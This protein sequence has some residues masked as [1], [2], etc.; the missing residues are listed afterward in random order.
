MMTF[1][2]PRDLIA[3]SHTCRLLNWK[4]FN[5]TQPGWYI[6][7]D[8]VQR[9]VALSIRSIISSSSR[10]DDSASFES[11]IG[12]SSGTTNR[13]RAVTKDPTAPRKNA[14]V[15]VDDDGNVID[16][17]G[18]IVRRLP[19]SEVEVIANAESSFTASSTAR[20]DRQQTEISD[21]KSSSERLPTRS[22]KRR[23]DFGSRPSSGDSG[24]DSDSDGSHQSQETDNEFDSS[25]SDA[26]SVAEQDSAVDPNSATVI[27]CLSHPYL[28]EDALDLQSLL[29]DEES[30][31]S[32]IRDLQ[33]FSKLSKTAQLAGEPLYNDLL[34][35]LKNN[36]LTRTTP[37]HFVFLERIGVWGDVGRA[38]IRFD[39]GLL[40]KVR[41]NGRTT[42]RVRTGACYGIF[43]DRAFQ[44][45]CL[46]AVLANRNKELRWLFNKVARGENL[47][48]EDLARL[49]SARRLMGVSGVYLI[50]IEVG[51]YSY[52][53]R[54]GC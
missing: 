25:G 53:P 40:R 16:L 32:D 42:Q 18:R 54:M 10:T 43:A 7:Q 4:V 28:S 27:P 26:Q 31:R 2:T 41:L 38:D 19:D 14:M 6:K 37:A 17:P 47:T 51:K 35:T 8:P 9:H 20:P 34:I 46:L 50:W 45:E 33:E 44:L 21:D 39:M 29:E 24:T 3:V 48:E 23:Q 15:D 52:T 49:Q 11:T 1:L 36:P 5:F 22:R 12:T 13:R 30:L